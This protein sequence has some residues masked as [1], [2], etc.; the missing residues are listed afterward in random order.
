MGPVGPV[1]LAFLGFTGKNEFWVLSLGPV[2][3]RWD[4]CGTAVVLAFLG[5]FALGPVG[6]VGLAYPGCDVKNEF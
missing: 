5:P 6:P 4:R 2:G 3:L 1:G